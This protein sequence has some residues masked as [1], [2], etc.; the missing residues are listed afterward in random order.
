MGGRRN[1]YGCFSYKCRAVSA[2]RF[3]LSIHKEQPA[4]KTWALHKCDNKICVNPDHLYWGDSA[5]NIRDAMERGLVPTGS[6][7]GTHTKP[8]SLRRFEDHHSAKL[9]KA[10]VIK[11]GKMVRSG[12]SKH[13][14]AKKYGVHLATVY[15]AAY[16][17][18]KLMAGKTET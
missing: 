7:N 1:D 16:R 14:I 9:T 8:E 5:D 17:A 12:V 10:D 13:L 6:R 2:H 15:K 3:S 11:I 18:A 4:G